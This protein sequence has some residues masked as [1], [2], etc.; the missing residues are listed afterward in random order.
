MLR[1]QFLKILA[2]IAVMLIILETAIIVALVAP[3]TLLKV[4][5]IAILKRLATL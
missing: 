3:L 4:T 5:E 2:L 1:E